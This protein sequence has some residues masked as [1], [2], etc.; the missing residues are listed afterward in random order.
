MEDFK[1]YKLPLTVIFVDI[2]KAAH[3]V[4]TSNGSSSQAL[5]LA[6][7]NGF[8]T[9]LQKTIRT[10]LKKGAI[11]EEAADTI[12][13]SQFIKGL[14]YDDIL[15][16]NLRLRER[17]DHPPKFMDLLDMVRKQ[18][19][20]LKRRKEQR[21]TGKEAQSKQV[22]QVDVSAEI[23]QRLQ[24]LEMQ[25]K[26]EAASKI[27]IAS[28]STTVPEVEHNQDLQYAQFATTTNRP[29]FCFKC[30]QDGHMQRNCPNTAND[31][32]VKQK[33]I[34]FVAP[35]RRNRSMDQGNYRRRRQLGNSA[36]NQAQ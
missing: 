17:T 27:S 3:T 5:F 9:R 13:L 36:S 7:S 32:L 25:S 2:K 18:E 10:A 19:N 8:L 16:V 6:C 22:L 33:L 29:R 20:E 11:D 26:Q 4:L 21:K 28:K 34:S 35:P 15:L 30:G 14:I 24:A 23:L 12:R 31:N 1:E